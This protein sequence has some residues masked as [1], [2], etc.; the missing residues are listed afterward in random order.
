MP[1]VNLTTV[2][3]AAVQFLGV[4]DSGEGLST[5]QKT[6]A[7]AVANNLL[8]NWSSEGVFIPTDTII[9]AIPVVAGTQSYTIGASQTI[10][11][12]RPVKIEA[13]SFLNSSGEG[14]PI[15]VVDEKKWASLPDRQG[16]SNHCRF[17]FYDRGYPTGTIYLSPVPL[18]T[19]PTLELHVFAP[20]TEFADLTTTISFAPGYLR[21][22]ELAL[23]VE[24]APQYDMQP[25][26]T[27]AASYSDA[28]KRIR[29]L[30]SSLIGELPPEVA[31]AAAKG[32]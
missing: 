13:A 31:G 7:L 18:S 28:V 26:E 10:N 24:L 25:S 21:P 3:Q 8:D 22:F 5:Q 32:A 23:A 12:A 9:K 16:Q 2:A 14:G 4:L 27:L 20:L 17:L 30:N 11:T 29:L 19:N 15:E 1:S 6:D